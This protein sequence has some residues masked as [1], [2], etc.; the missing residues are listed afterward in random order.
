[1]VWKDLLNKAR[2]DPNSLKTWDGYIASARKI[3]SILGPDGISGAALVG[4]NYSPDLWYPYLWM[5]GGDI[6]VM[7][8]G[9]PVKGSYGFQLIIAPAG[10]KA[11][12]FIKEQVNLRDKTTE[13]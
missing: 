11:L 5:L 9:H 2:V 4:L 7:K 8:S 13:E 6:I 12:E 3:N 1:M 10:V